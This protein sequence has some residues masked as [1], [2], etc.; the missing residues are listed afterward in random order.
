MTVAGRT[1]GLTGL[2][3][4][5]LLAVVSGSAHATPRTYTVVIDKMIYSPAIL[6]VKAGDTVIWVNHDIF[7]HSA[8][9]KDHSFNID[10]VSKGT[11]KTTLKRAGVM[12]YTCTFHPGMKGKITVTP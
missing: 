6:T 7:R 4:V 10:M 3:A 12:V 2:A 8:T 1:S 11:G 9:A 5:A